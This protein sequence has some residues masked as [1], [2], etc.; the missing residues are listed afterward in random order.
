[1][2]DPK[3]MVFGEPTSAV[4]PEMVKEVLDTMVSLADEG[5]TMIVTHERGFARQVAT[6]SSGPLCLGWRRLRNGRRVV[7][8][9][10]TS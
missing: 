8:G 3:I 2:H 5:M 6:E 1:M 7:G 4:G 9:V 10:A